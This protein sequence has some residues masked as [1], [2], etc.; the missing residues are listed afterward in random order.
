MG[1]PH[2]LTSNQLIEQR[3]ESTYRCITCPPLLGR[4]YNPDQYSAPYIIKATP[5]ILK[6]KAKVRMHADLS[7]T[8]S[9][10]FGATHFFLY[11]IVVRPFLYSCQVLPLSEGRLRILLPI[12][13]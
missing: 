3:A 5:T 6:G 4:Y 8:P 10:A 2:T 1:K 12:R 7:L 9:C 13:P 11:V